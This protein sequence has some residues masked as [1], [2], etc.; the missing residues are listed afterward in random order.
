[1]APPLAS[2]PGAARPHGYRRAVFR[3]LHRPTFLRTGAELL[4]FVNVALALTYDYVQRIRLF[5]AA[6]GRWSLHQEIVTSQAEDPYR[7]RV[8]VPGAVEVLRRMGLG[9][10]GGEG[11]DQLYGWYFLLALIALMLACRRMLSDFG[12]DRGHAIAGALLVGAVLP[13]ALRD[14]G[15]QPWSWLE[16]VTVALALCLCVR[17]PRPLLFAGLVFVATLNRE[18]AL[19]VPA[20]AVAAAWSWRRDRERRNRWLLAAG[21][22]YAAWGAARACVY[23]YVGR[24]SDRAITLEQI[25]ALNTAPGAGRRTFEAFA[26]LLGGVL[27]CAGL[28][29][30]G[31]RLGALPFW[32][33]VLVVPQ[34]LVG[35]AVWAVWYEVRVL[36]PVLVLALPAA[37]AAL[38]APSPGVDLPS[39]PLRTPPHA[40][41]RDPAADVDGPLAEHAGGRPSPVASR[42]LAR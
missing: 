16:A 31:K 20:I 34:Y 24:A 33:V 28:A 23:L 14:H 25:L 39:R 21:A 42:S 2:R 13:V 11:L 30:V 35:W 27:L 10:D 37:M 9:G 19:F 5:D 8:L 17:R 6:N 29:A 26:L 1:M 36:V 22:G 4:L 18:T 38:A 15:F 3:A 41:R 32:V 12:F 7:Y 40:G